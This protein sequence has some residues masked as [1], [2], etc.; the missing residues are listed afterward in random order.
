MKEYRIKT[1]YISENITKYIIQEKSWLF[2]WVSSKDAEEPYY[3]AMI[4]AERDL[5]DIHYHNETKH[6]HRIR[7]NGEIYITT[8]D[9]FKQRRVKEQMEKLRNSGLIE[10]IDERNSAL[11]KEKKRRKNINNILNNK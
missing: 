6:F 8:A 10:E 3:F 11:R 9:F 1:K 5:E 4:D 7:K 2:G